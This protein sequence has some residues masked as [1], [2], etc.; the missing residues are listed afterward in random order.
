MTPIDT[1]RFGTVSK[2]VGKLV[3]FADRLPASANLIKAKKGP[4]ASK[5]DSNLVKQ[6]P[7]NLNQH[8]LH[9]IGKPRI[10]QA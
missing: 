9:L 2:S 10:A 5:N 4:G 6:T 1:D 3:S 8:H 7:E